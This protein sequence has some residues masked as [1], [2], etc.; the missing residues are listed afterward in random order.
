MK[1]RQHRQNPCQ[2]SRA[3]IEPCL[4]V[5][6]AVAS[7]CGLYQVANTP[8]VCAL[9]QSLRLPVAVAELPEFQR[10]QSDLLSPAQTHGGVPGS[11]RIQNYADTVT[12]CKNTSHRPR[13]VLHQQRY[14]SLLRI[15]D[16]GS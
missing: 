15:A 13:L 3:Y 1:N 9:S 14:V 10:L 16:A 7:C 8:W 5:P 11:D 12:G 2:T 4:K 6:K